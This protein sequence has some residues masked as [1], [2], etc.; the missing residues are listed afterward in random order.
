[1]IYTSRLDVAKASFIPNV[2]RL[3]V[4]R[5]WPVNLRP[6]GQRQLF[7]PRAVATSSSGQSAPE[8]TEGFPLRKGDT[9]QAKITRIAYGGAAVGEIVHPD[10]LLPAD[11]LI[12]VYGPKGACPGDT[13]ECNVTKVR[14]RKRDPEA[15]VVNNT[16]STSSDTP[17]RTYAEVSF[18]KLLVPSPV[19]V[20]APC[21]HFGNHHLGGGGCGGCTSMHI[22][23]SMQLEQKQRQLESLFAVLKEEYGVAD[24]AVIPCRDT[25]GYRNKMEFSY[26]RKWYTRPMK[27]ET[28][29]DATEPEYALGLHAPQ[30]F[31][32]VV[33]ITECHIQPSVANKILNFV[34]EEAQRLLLE[35]YDTKQDTGY[36]RNIAIRTSTNSKGQIEV[37]VNIITS[38]CDVPNRL[39]PL[40]QSIKYTFPEVVCVLQNLRG[41]KSSF[42]VDESQERLLT[43]D[44]RYIEQEL[45]GLTFRI[46]ANSFFQTNADQA[47]VLYEN[48]RRAAKLTPDD[49]VLDLF[50]GTGTISLCLARSAKQVYGI[51]VVAAA[52]NDARKNALVNRITNATFEEGN[53]DKLK[54][55]KGTKALL[56]P[57]VIVVD[58][59][60]QGYIQIWSSISQVLK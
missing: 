50:C 57:D 49:V 53:L 60:A 41:V 40:A 30:R 54:S 18:R 26:G 8:E 1:M 39:K 28:R 23:Y 27:R 32:K 59:R 43:G 55:S 11:K 37:M 33:S 12:P 44:R 38:P 21:A 52:I 17:T 4:T 2:F 16:G 14:R 20:Q 48:V 46:S 7:V 56:E 3:P 51:D 42:S 31:D 15:Y 25:L 9:I 34:R 13:I 35:P 29:L 6:P 36:L 10:N 22:T 45:C 24:F 19:T 58:P 47:E 5:R